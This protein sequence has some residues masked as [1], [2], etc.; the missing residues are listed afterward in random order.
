MFSEM[1]CKGGGGRRGGRM[2]L[3]FEVHFLFFK[4]PT[5]IPLS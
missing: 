2:E 1:V 3:F 5:A 4:V